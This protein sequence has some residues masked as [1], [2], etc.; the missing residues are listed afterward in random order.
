MKL[1][2]QP[3]VMTQMTQV[4]AKGSFMLDCLPATLCLHVTLCHGTFGWPYVM[5]SSDLHH[6]RLALAGM[7]FVYYFHCYMLSLHS[8]EH[9]QM[10]MCTL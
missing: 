5:A 6:M 3:A 10:C 4:T 1:L 2:Q 9:S 7:R 8:T